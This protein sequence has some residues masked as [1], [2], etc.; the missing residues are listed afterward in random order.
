MPPPAR[1]QPT[2][3]Q[4]TM[5]SIFERA[6]PFFRRRDNRYMS[7][8]SNSEVSGPRRPDR[9]N[10]TSM[11]TAFKWCDPSSELLGLAFI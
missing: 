8:T 9:G 11:S 3:H 5:M 1:T 4:S 6:L 10:S 7:M 2:H